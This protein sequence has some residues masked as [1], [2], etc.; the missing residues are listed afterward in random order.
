MGPLL[1]P[2][3]TMLGDFLIRYSSVGVDR[4][5]TFV[6]VVL[7]NALLFRI[8]ENISTEGLKENVELFSENLKERSDCR[9]WNAQYLS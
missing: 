2:N 7:Y 6:I 4:G 5:L 1:Y 9:R 3:F 8:S